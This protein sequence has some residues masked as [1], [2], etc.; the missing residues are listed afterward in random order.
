MVTASTTFADGQDLGSWSVDC[1]TQTV[2]W[3]PGMFLLFSRDHGTFAPTIAEMRA[4]CPS[5]GDAMF[6]WALRPDLAD[7]QHFGSSLITSRGATEVTTI[8]I[9]ATPHVLNSHL[10][11]VSGV[12]HNPRTNEYQHISSLEQELRYQMLFRYAPNGLIQAAPS[13]RIILVNP[14]FCKLVG[15]TSEELLTMTTDDITHPEDHAVTAEAVRK[16]TSGEAEHCSYD[17]RYLHKDGFCV[18]IRLSVSLF[19][20]SDGRPLN[21]IGQCQDISARRELENSLTVS[22]REER[23]QRKAVEKQNEELAELATIDALTKVRN[24]AALD[25]ALDVLRSKPEAGSFAL[26]SIEIGSIALRNRTHGAPAVDDL[27][28]SVAQALIKA[29]GNAVCIARISGGHFRVL[30][31]EPDA[32]TLRLTREAIEAEIEGIR[33]RRSAVTPIISE[34]VCRRVAALKESQLSKQMVRDN[35]LAAPGV[36]AALSGPLDGI[37]SW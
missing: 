20:G 32:K 16:L 35:V 10:I 28:R 6:S 17:K 30:L 25:T 24:R 37:S 29:C 23:E 34:E 13:K 15:Y 1:E 4:L 11:R 12:C 9:S 14:A 5:L 27:L 22:L 3:S 8:L 2:S 7:G 36:V 26:F 21:Y 18:W 31:D 19:R 33:W